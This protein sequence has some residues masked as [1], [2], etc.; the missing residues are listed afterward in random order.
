[1]RRSSSSPSA[2]A[3]LVVVTALH[4]ICAA[5]GLEYPTPP[6]PFA[7]PSQPPSAGELLQQGGAVPP[8]TPFAPSSSS[9]SGFDG[10]G[11]L[12]GGPPSDAPPLPGDAVMPPLPSGDPPPND[13]GAAAAPARPADD[14]ALP[15]KFDEKGLTNEPRAKSGFL[16]I[17]PTL[18]LAALSAACVVTRPREAAL[19]AALDAHHDAWGHLIADGLRDQPIAMLD[20]GLGTAAVHSG[21]VWVGMLGQWLPLL[22]SSLDALQTW[23]ATVGAPQLLLLALTFGYLLRKATPRAAAGAH[24]G[25]SL[26]GLLGRGRLH[27]LVTA[28]FSPVGLVHWLHAVLAVLACTPGLIGADVGMSRGR[29]VGLF[30]AA[31]ACSALLCV[32]TQLLFG[33][34]KQP[35]SS[36]SGGVMGLLL[37][38]CALLPDEPID[39]GGGVS[40]K[41]LRL[42]LAHV[43]L[44]GFSNSLPEPPRPLGIEKLLALFGAAFLVAGLQP[45]LREAVTGALRSGMSLQDVLEFVKAAW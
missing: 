12:P 45:S 40:L 16:R 35:R 11:L 7:K 15:V 14:D 6:N 17:R 38:R 28:T 44:D 13:G 8:P 1:M 33:R 24:L 9:S 42:V 18:C 30:A 39:L 21:L 25:V 10:G 19:T 37:L 31:G 34:R 36:L 29:V 5:S 3:S 41:P 43:V 32:V 4:L 23:S 27:T 2:T 26:H 20:G 22:P